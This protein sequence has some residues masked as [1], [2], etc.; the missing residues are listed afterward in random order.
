MGFAQ[1]AEAASFGVLPFHTSK[2]LSDARNASRKRDLAA[3]A[4]H[5][6]AYLKARPRRAELWVQ[7]G[8][9]LKDD[10]HHS[11]AEAAYRQAI[12]LAP[13]APDAYRQLGHLLKR[14]G[15]LQQAA[16][17]FQRGLVVAPDTVDLRDEVLGGG[18]PPAAMDATL[19]RAALSIGPASA[20][21]RRRGRGP[22]DRFRVVLH[23]WLARQAAR[24]RRWHD[25]ARH[26]KRLLAIE[27][28]RP[29]AHLQ[30]GHAL[31]EAGDTDYGINSYWSAV[32]WSPHFTDAY[33][34][35]GQGLKLAGNVAGAELAMLT[36]LRLRPSHERA[37]ADLLAFGWPSGRLDQI[38]SDTWSVPAK[39]DERGPVTVIERVYENRPPLPLMPSGLSRREQ[40]LWNDLRATVAGA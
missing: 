22:A 36:A 14:T 28:N 1:W 29:A 7:Y 34:A 11:E 35:L 5:Y 13:H 18:L 30:L 23:L 6:A 8:H 33:Y 20:I 39:T 2:L 40:I 9:V 15:R 12:A 17:V 25:A 16:E 32:A 24:A 3:A 38:V 10:G 27:P 21:E 37:R 26:Y 4:S 31:K 19:L